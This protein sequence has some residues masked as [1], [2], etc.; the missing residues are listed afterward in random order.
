MYT[1]WYP[2]TI[3]IMLVFLCGLPVAYGYI[4][5]WLYFGLHQVGSSSNEI[6]YPLTWMA[7]AI[8]GFFLMLATL[9]Y[10]IEAVQ[11]LFMRHWYK[12]FSDF[13][14]YRQGYNNRQAGL[15]VAKYAI[16]LFMLS[17]P[18]TFTSHVTLKKD[19]V[20]INKFYQLLSDE[21][22][23]TE[24]KAI[25]RYEK[26]QNRD[27]QLHN[28]PYYLVSFTDND[29]FAPSFYF[30]PAQQEEFLTELTHRAGINITHIPIK[31]FEK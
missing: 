28:G 26:I 23:Y 3:T 19:T 24:I 15:F 14:D 1:Y 12:P 5:Y 18:F 30:E 27:G 29:E 2:L 31:Y 16:I 13:Y 9:Q 6:F 17:L 11:R 21:Y 4:I 8:N 22:R 7:F 20:S 25:T 10:T